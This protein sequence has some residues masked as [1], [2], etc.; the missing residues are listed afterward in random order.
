MSSE[1]QRLENKIHYFEDMM[2]RCKGY[3]YQ[4]VETIRKKYLICVFSYK[5][6]DLGI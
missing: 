3:E 1:E 2:F 4:K 5:E 6:F